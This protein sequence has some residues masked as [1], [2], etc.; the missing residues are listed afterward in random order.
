MA[1]Q[2]FKR[3]QEKNTDIKASQVFVPGG[4]PTVTYNPRDEYKLEESVKEASENLSKL[5]VITGPTKSGKTVLVDKIYPRDDTVWIDSGSV[6]NEDSFWD[7]IVDQLGGYTE[8]ETEDA[9]EDALDGQ[10]ES[11]ISVGKLMKLETKA[12]IGVS[13]TRRK[14]E[15]MRHKSGNKTIA[16]S[17]LNEAKIPVVV[18]DFHYLEKELQK[19]IVRA[20][21][22]PIMHG[23]PVIF[24]AIPSR[25]YDAIEVEKEMTGRIRNISMPK[26][27]KED[28][29]HI[30]ETGFKV[31]NVNIPDE[32]IENMALKAY[33]SPFLMQ[34]FC[35]SL[36]KWNDIHEVCKEELQIDKNF[37][38]S[39]IYKEL[40][41]DTGQPVFNRLKRGPRA[42]KDRK[43]R[44]LKSGAEMDIYGIVMESL[45]E[46]KPGISSLKYEDLRNNI[47]AILDEEP[48]RKN[49]ITRVLDKIAEISYT[50]SSSAPIIDWRKDEDI[51]TITD[52]FFA[53]YL[54]WAS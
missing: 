7:L 37:E 46:I 31:L 34:E 16:L 21:K 35:R 51:L 25:R 44:N 36:C 53:F 23:L 5:L 24:I 3:W 15:I 11:G 14:T 32:I 19:S 10:V 49:E 4:V 40:A 38:M 45:K 50:E 12:K 47:K 54:E 27:E 41:D 18:D 33:G 52:P 42:R 8:F 26:W 2:L 28:L 43:I 1:K 20:L 22:G 9:E 17:I 13:D 39:N 29:C 30:A 6:S 48:P